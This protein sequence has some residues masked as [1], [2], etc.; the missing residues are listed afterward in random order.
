LA[1]AWQGRLARPDLPNKAWKSRLAADLADA[2]GGYWYAWVDG[3]GISGGYGWGEKLNYIV[4]GVPIG[5]ASPQLI[6]AGR[7]RPDGSAAFLVAGLDG[8]EVKIKEFTYRYIPAR[9]IGARPQPSP[10]GDAG[11]YG[12]NPAIRTLAFGG[13]ALPARILARYVP[14]GADAEIVLLWAAVEAGET[15]LLMRHYRPGETGATGAP[16]V[17]YA[18]REPLVAMAMEPVALPVIPAVVD[19]LFG[20][21]GEKD[22]RHMTLIRI[23]LAGP[24]QPLE[25][26]FREPSR[27]IDANTTRFPDRWALASWPAEDPPVLARLEQNLLCLWPTSGS[28][29]AIFAQ[30]AAAVEHIR[31][32]VLPRL[33]RSRGARHESGS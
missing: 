3:D 19:A 2:M 20:P 27:T 24:A 32:A 33:D 9:R 26:R 17:L 30:D 1:L 10:P 6:A 11:A 12:P 13:S 22:Q 29:P 16:K 15:Q 21:A 7:R 8:R 31:L 23:P 18:R 28:P 5:L 14:N 25:W 4:P